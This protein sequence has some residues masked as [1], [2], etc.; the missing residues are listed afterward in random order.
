MSTNISLE[1]LK[2]IA[3]L[4]KLRFADD[5]LEKFIS[6]FNSILGYID[7]IK[8][9]D[10]AGLE[11]EHHLSAYSDQVLQEDIS[12]PSMSRDDFLKNATERQEKGYIKTSQIV[13]KG[14]AE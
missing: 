3:N 5:E 4:A 8:Q 2:K 12:K 11:P 14:G 1:E 7:Q 6:E 13:S 9:C 10:T